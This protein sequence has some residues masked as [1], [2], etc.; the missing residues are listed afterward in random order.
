MIFII[1]LRTGLRRGEL[2]GSRWEHVDLARGILTVVESRVRVS[3]GVKVER[4]KGQRSRR[5]D[6]SEEEVELLEVHAAR[7]EQRRAAAGEAWVSGDHV[8]TRSDGRPITPST[9][10]RRWA[11]LLEKVGVPK[12]RPHDLRHLNLSLLIEA[13]TNVKVVQNRAGHYSAAFTL[14]R[15]GHVLDSGRKRAADAIGTALSQKRRAP[16]SQ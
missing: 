9:F 4:P 15:Y 5:I 1:K 2:L 14:D 10:G 13:G 7:Q 8:F 11:V 16:D 3:G 6:L 12:I